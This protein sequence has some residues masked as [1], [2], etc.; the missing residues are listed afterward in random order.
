MKTCHN[1]SN[2]NLKRYIPC[3]NSECK[4][5]Y[6][7]KCLK[8]YYGCNKKTK[9]YLQMKTVN[10][11]YINLRSAVDKKKWKCFY[12]RGTCKCKACKKK[13]KIGDKKK[14]MK[15]EKDLEKTKEKNYVKIDDYIIYEDEEDNLTDNNIKT[16]VLND[17]FQSIKESENFAKEAKNITETNNNINENGKYSFFLQ[18][19][20]KFQREKQTKREG[21]D[22][23][24]SQQSQK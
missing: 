4:K 12:C 15:D 24:H 1:C 10:E 18:R 2:K 6:C 14:S 20:W 19:K 13:N 23:Y 21:K 7:Y 5:N 9:I 11:N 8:L 22:F 3:S 17:E 16:I